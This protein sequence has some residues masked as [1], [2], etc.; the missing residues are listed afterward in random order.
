MNRDRLLLLQKML[1]EISEHQWKPEPFSYYHL[2]YLLFK[3]KVY[4]KTNLA[5][6][7]KYWCSKGNNGWTACAVGH[8]ML[9]K[10]FTALGLKRTDT[11][12]PE[13]N[14][15]YGM[16]A[17][18]AFFE[19]DIETAM[20]LFAPTSYSTDCYPNPIYVSLR[21]DWLIEND[22][23]NANRFK[24]SFNKYGKVL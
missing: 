16:R 20:I 17:A 12:I 6:N 15:K 3:L 14:G 9:D 10:R 18:A 2:P 1:N 13:Y 19:I 22:R 24:N 23:C 21:I 8:A 11:L 4:R 7:I 5:F